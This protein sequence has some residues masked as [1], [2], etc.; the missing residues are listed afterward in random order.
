MTEAMY[1]LEQHRQGR[2]LEMMNTEFEDLRVSSG[3]RAQTQVV[4][5]QPQ[6]IIDR[7]KA[8][9]QKHSKNFDLQEWSQTGSAAPVTP[10]PI[11]VNDPTNFADQSIHENLIIQAEQSEKILKVG[12]DARVYL[13]GQDIEIVQEE[14]DQVDETRLGKIGEVIQFEATENGGLPNSSS[15][16]HYAY[17]SMTLKDS[18]FEQMLATRSNMLQYETEEQTQSDLKEVVKMKGVEGY[19]KTPS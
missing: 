10:P 11:I 5:S 9:N 17:N 16:Q 3:D 19:I 4:Q 18:E 14:R 2:L 13:A 12:E 15:T 6:N 7:E 1:W 8:F